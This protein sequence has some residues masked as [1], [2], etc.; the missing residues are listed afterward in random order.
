MRFI[1]QA[2]LAR[3]HRPLHRVWIADPEAGGRKLPVCT[4]RQSSDAS[5][6]AV[7]SRPPAHPTL[8]R[9]QVRRIKTT[10]RQR[11]EASG[12]WP[13]LPTACA[14]LPGRCTRQTHA[15]APGGLASG[16]GPKPMARFSVSA[17]VMGQ[18]L[19]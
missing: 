16:S 6:D 1:A 12:R 17:P 8:G 13:T 3:M 19:L 11:P 14:N 15:H 18:G 2:A 7:K 10:T 4:G 5:V 9:R